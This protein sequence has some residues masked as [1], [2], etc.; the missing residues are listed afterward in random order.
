MRIH[1]VV[2]PEESWY[3]SRV[4][5]KQHAAH[6]SG[7]GAYVPERRLHNEELAQIMDT[8]DDWIYSHTGIRYRHVAAEEEAASDLAVKAAHGALDAAHLA[9]EAVD[10]VLV[11]TSTP[12]YIGLPS[13]AC[14][15]QDKLRITGAGAMDLVAACTGFI[16]GLETARTF[17][18]AGAARHVLVIGSEVYSR[19]VN[20]EDRKSSVLFGD[21]AGAV[22]V[23]AVDTARSAPAAG[24]I[25]PALLG[26]RGSGAETLCRLH[27]G[28]RH[29]YVPGVTP[30]SA[31]LLQMDGRSVYTF[32]VAALVEVIQTLLERNRLSFQDIAWVVPHQANTRIIT[33]AARR[34]GWDAERFYMN[35]EEYANTSAASIPIALDEMNRKK[36]LSPGDL[37]LFVGF[38]SGLTYGGNLLRW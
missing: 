17:I 27:G 22:V 26:S 28:T 6:I 31:T 19:I 29:P 13:T 10:L 30:E 32:A 33:A 9:P 11:A 21:G 36:L 38:G 16:Y 24:H 5:L 7:I 1:S 34:G 37:L 8:S 18:A 20:W 4:E 23:S 2:F 14:V 25:F 15:V 35:I 3:L 12:D